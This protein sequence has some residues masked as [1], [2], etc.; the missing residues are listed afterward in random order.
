MQTMRQTVDANLEGTADKGREAGENY[1]VGLA[2]GI[3]NGTSAVDKAIKRLVDDAIVGAVNNRLEIRS[4][5]R[6]GMEQGKFYDEGIAQGIE[7]NSGTVTSASL[8]MISDLESASQ[9]AAAAAGK[10]LG[11]TMAKSMADALKAGQ[12][13]R[14]AAES[15]NLT[16][17]GN[18]VQTAA[19]AGIPSL[20]GQAALDW[21]A[22]QKRD[23]GL[24]DDWS[25]QDIVDWLNGGGAQSGGMSS[26]TKA[27]IESA[28]KNESTGSHL[29]TVNRTGGYGKVTKYDPE[30]RSKLNSSGSVV[31]NQTFNGNTSAYQAGKA[32]EKAGTDLVFK[33]Y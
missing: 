31:I 28:V 18:K 26:T 20:S 33:Y 15:G 17:N 11:D 16:V 6:V 23:F 19:Q 27:N 25:N 30:W 8:K 21:N 12:A 13:L 29:I 1:T 2:E 14:Q 10:S 4:P 5:S 22:E 32:V 24:P 3:E 7:R 9:S